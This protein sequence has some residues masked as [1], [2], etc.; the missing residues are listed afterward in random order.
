MKFWSEVK[1]KVIETCI[2]HGKQ[3]EDVCLI[4]IE[5]INQYQRLWELF[6]RERGGEK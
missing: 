6:R 1:K 2:E 5:D 3:Y 4:L